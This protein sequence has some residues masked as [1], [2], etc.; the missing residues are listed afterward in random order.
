MEFMLDQ[1]TYNSSLLPIHHHF[2]HFFFFGQN[3]QQ[4]RKIVT[5]GER[6]TTGNK[7]PGQYKELTL[8]E[9]KGLSLSKV[10]C[11]TL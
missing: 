6:C 7:S 1:Q 9:Q 10:P 5:T 4:R 8:T 3:N 11:A 2:L